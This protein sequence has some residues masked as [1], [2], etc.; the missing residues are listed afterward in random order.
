ME[1][2]NQTPVKISML[3]YQNKVVAVA[4]ECKFMSMKALRDFVKSQAEFLKHKAQE[5]ARAH[6]R[7]KRA[8]VQN[9]TSK[10]FIQL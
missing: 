2:N 3:N 8:L 9:Q 1:I 10:I 7:P 6:L 4:N 5:Q